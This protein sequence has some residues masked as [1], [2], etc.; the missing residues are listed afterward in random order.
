MDFT[1]EAMQKTLDIARPELHLVEDVHG[2]KATFST[3]PLRQVEAVAPKLPVPVRVNTLAGF[4]DLVKA[5]LED[6]P[7]SDDFVIHVEDDHTVTLKGRVSDGY[8]RRMEL[9][10]AQPVEFRQFAFGQLHDQ[11]AFVIAVASLFA[12][13]GDKDYVLKT[14]SIL[15]NEATNTTEDDG[16]TQRATVKAGLRTKESVTL[17][18]RVSLAPYRTFPEVAQPISD[19]VFRARCAGDGVPALMLVEADGGRWRPGPHARG[20]RWRAMEGPGHRHSPGGHGGLWPRH[21]HH[22]LGAEVAHA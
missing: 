11:E 5:K 7:F 14:A 18:P 21:S 8:G 22:C 3:K 20:G 4:A 6:Q 1:S 2:V 15:T 16:F 10:K 17:K 12:E 9:I 13:G 19:F